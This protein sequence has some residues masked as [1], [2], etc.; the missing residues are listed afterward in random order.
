MSKTKK[1]EEIEK[2]DEEEEIKKED[3]EKIKLLINVMNQFLARKKINNEQ[4]H[5]EFIHEFI[6]KMVLSLTSLKISEKDEMKT[7][8]GKINQGNLE[9]AIEDLTN[10]ISRLTISLLQKKKKE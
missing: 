6:N 8:I 5:Q 9:E 10:F 1:K 2:E 4:I 3:I 7:I